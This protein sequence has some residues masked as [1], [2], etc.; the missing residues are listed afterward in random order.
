MKRLRNMLDAN[1]RNRLAQT[2]RTLHYL[3]H[4]HD[5]VDDWIIPVWS[6]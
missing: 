1:S 2:S 5:I 4:V 6:W 3:A